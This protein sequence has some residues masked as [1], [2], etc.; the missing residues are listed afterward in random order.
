MLL[1]WLLTYLFDSK[2]IEMNPLQQRVG[3]NNLCVGWDTAPAK[4]VAAPIYV[5]IICLN[6]RF[7]QLDYWRAALNPKITAFQQRAVLVCNVCSTVS[8]TVSILIFVM[9]P[10]ESPEGHTAAFLQLVVFGYIAYAANFL[11]ADSDYH[12]RGS[13]AF[14]AIFGVVSALFGSCAVVQFVTYEPETGSRGPI[15]WYVTAVGDYLWF[16]CLGAQGYFR[17]RAPSITLSFILCSDEDFTQPS[18]EEAA[19]IEMVVEPNDKQVRQVS[20]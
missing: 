6:A 10:K 11:E 20:I 18:Y 13:Q 1:S 5:I 4:C 12:V 9:D 2:S 8:W 3:Y 14:L 16:G 19:E 7:M 17:P 15:P